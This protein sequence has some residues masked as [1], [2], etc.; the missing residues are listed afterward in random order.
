VITTALAESDSRRS[1]AV[2]ICDELPEL[3]T[4][5]GA[6]ISVIDD[7]GTRGTV[8]ASD[9]VMAEVEELQFVTGTGPCVDA[10]TTA[11]PVLIPDLVPVGH[12]RWPEFAEPAIRS[13]VRAIFAFP[14]GIGAIRLGALD[15]YRS[16]P[17][18][19]TKPHL[20]D[21]LLC[22]DG[23]TAALIHMHDEAPAGTV[24]GEWWDPSSFFHVEVHQATGM[25]MAQ[26][27]ITA[28]EALLRLRSAAFGLGRPVSELA[29]AIVTGATRFGPDGTV[30]TE[31]P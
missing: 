6:A 11:Q 30:V 15:L 1:A 25:V 29:H 3:L 21:A 19:L 26:L 2:R 24:D 31:A 10:Y 14:L 22:A 28:G 13:G 4:V 20:A 8:C 12:S 9:S 18:A 23:A 5:T 7:D 16:T 17:G 27:D